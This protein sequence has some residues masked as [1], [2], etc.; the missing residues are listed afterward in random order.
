MSVAPMRETA[1]IQRE[2][3]VGR[4]AGLDSQSSGH[5]WGCVELWWNRKGHTT[6]GL[7]RIQHGA[8]TVSSGFAISCAHPPTLPT[9]PTDPTHPP[10]TPNHPR[11][12]THACV[13]ACAA[14]TRRTPKATAS[15]ASPPSPAKL[16]KMPKSHGICDV[17]R[18]VAPAPLSQKPAHL[19]ANM[20]AMSGHPPK[21]TLRPSFL[22]VG[23]VQG[24]LASPAAGDAGACWRL[25]GAICAI[26]AVFL[27]SLFFPRR[28]DNVASEARRKARDVGNVLGS[29]RLGWPASG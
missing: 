18:V 9:L 2:T 10:T 11:A 19:I 15:P 6:S 8:I 28:L 24:M 29:K 4:K 7:N 27:F 20:P 21:L 25:S 14:C 23:A 5:L 22:R 1:P 16:G 3:K 17:F 26:F 13:H 12:R